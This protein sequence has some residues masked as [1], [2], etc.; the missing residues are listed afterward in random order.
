MIWIQ[1]RSDNLP[2]DPVLNFFTKFGFKN[3]KIDDKQLIGQNIARYA[4]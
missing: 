1:G 4:G 3:T 2:W